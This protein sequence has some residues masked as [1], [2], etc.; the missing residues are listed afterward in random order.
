MKWC[1][2]KISAERNGDLIFRC[3]G[4]NLKRVFEINRRVVGMQP[5]RL[6]AT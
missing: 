2:Y 5:A 6:R 1:G 3:V 4:R